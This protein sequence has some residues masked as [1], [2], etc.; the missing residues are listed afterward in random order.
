MVGSGCGS[1]SPFHRVGS[2]MRVWQPG[3]VTGCGEVEAPD[4][5]REAGDA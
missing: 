4:G 3:G 1:G 2:G 5:G